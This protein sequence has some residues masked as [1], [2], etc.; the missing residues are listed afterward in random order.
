M[1]KIKVTLKE[2]YD[3]KVFEFDERDNADIKITEVER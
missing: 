3:G 2:E 1:A